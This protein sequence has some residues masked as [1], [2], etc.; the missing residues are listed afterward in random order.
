ME[1]IQLKVIAPEGELV[2]RE[3]QV[4]SLCS[5]AGIIEI[6]VMHEDMIMQLKAGDILCDKE[7]IMAIKSGFAIISHNLCEIV[8]ES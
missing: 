4:I 5:T 2:S 3:C 1:K 6:M 7:K 8:I